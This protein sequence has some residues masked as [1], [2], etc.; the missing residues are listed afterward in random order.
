MYYITHHRIHGLSFTQFP[1]SISQRIALGAVWPMIEVSCL[2][3]MGGVLLYMSS[4]IRTT[5]LAS[6]E[7]TAER[8]GYVG[9][10]DWG[11]QWPRYSVLGTP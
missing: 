8:G 10:S 7:E 6:S 11:C 1:F 2:R 9:G 4:A 5:I 3:E